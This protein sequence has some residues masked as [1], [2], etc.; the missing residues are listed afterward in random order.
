VVDAGALAAVTVTGGLAAR[1]ARLARRRDLRLAPAQRTF[2][3]AGVAALAGALL[4][5]LDHR[6]S[7]SVAAH[8]AQ[9][10][11]LADIAV[12][13]LL[14]GFRAPVGALAVPKRL[15]AAF[16]RARRLRRALAILARPTVAVPLYAVVLLGWHV[17]PAFEAA[18]RHPLVHAL[19]HQ[20]FV[21]ASALV[22]WPLIEPHRRQARGELWKLAYLFAARFFGMA[23]AMAIAAARTPL[24]ADAYGAGDRAF[25]LDA[26]ADQRLGAALMFTT[27]VVVLAVGMTALF[28]LAAR[29]GDRPGDATGPRSRR[30][31]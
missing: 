11:L 12:P 28:F 26:L 9:H 19:Q 16:G 31:V 23:L 29:A 21:V 25:G 6:A 20:A 14:L 22:W 2:C 8:M 24:Y 27:D 30:T 4:S 5:P 18:L 15:V 13:L 7:E 10:L 1:G 17:G 3:V